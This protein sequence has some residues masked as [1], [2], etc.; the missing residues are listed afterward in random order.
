M[1]LESSEK[2]VLFAEMTEVLVRSNPKL[3]RKKIIMALE[4]RER[5]RNTCVFSKIGIPH[6]NCDGLTEPLIA[7]GI[8]RDGIDYECVSYSSE[9]YKES[10]VHLVIMI[11]FEPGDA[12]LHLKVLADCARVLTVPGFYEAVLKAESPSQVLNVIREFETEQ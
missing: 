9:H 3:N 7:L 1:N 2:D 4:E 8:S 11:L 10:L 6:I 12:E 5:K